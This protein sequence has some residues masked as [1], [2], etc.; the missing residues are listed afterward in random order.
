MLSVAILLTVAKVDLAFHLCLLRLPRHS[1]AGKMA[2]N[3]DGE[4]YDPK[5][6]MVSW[7]NNDISWST[8]EL[9]SNKGI[10]YSRE[11]DV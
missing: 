11:P 6:S 1:M 7:L 2:G 5:P 10:G 3:D 4:E 8:P 9:A